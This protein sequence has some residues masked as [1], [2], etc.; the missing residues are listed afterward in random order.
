LP[1]HPTLSYKT[2]LSEWKNYILDVKVNN[3]YSVWK[4]RSIVQLHQFL[5]SHTWPILSVLQ[6]CII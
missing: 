5:H 2:Y 3:F 4:Q 6:L 1:Q